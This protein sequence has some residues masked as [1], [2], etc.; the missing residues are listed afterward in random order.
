MATIDMTS[1]RCITASECVCESIFTHKI[2][3]NVFV[4]IKNKTKYAHNFRNV[5]CQRSN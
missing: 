3:L 4:K 2:L 1:K 5:F